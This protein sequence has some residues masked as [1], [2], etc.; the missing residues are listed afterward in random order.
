MLGLQNQIASA[1]AKQIRMTLIPRDQIR[2]G[3]ERPSNPVSYES[4]L[5]G[6]YFLNRFTPDSISKAADYFQQAIEEDPNYVPAYVKL[7][8]SYQMLANMN[9]I[10]KKTA[11]AKAKS[12]V[13][14]ALR[15]LDPQFAAAH[16]VEG[17]RLLLYELDFAAAAPEFNVL[18]S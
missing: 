16:A 8:G 13:A 6:E 17:W 15:E 3:I 10:P 1:I 4:Y 18:S 9:V 11:Y 14:R 5:R 2:A 7:A 12:L